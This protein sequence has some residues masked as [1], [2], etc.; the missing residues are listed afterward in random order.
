MAIVKLVNCPKCGTHLEVEITDVNVTLHEQQ[1]NDA[2]T[3]HQPAQEVKLA[4][5]NAADQKIEALRAAGINTSNL[6]SI[7]VAKGQYK[8]GCGEGNHLV[9]LEDDNPIF[10]AILKDGTIPDRRLFRRWVM[11]QVFHMLTETDHNGKVI[12]FSKLL[13]HKGYKYQWTMVIEELRVQAKLYEN[14]KENYLERNRWFNRSAVVEM[15]KDYIENIKE[16]VNQPKHPK[17]KGEPYV[18]FDKNDIFLK[19]IPEKVNEP[20]RKAL[21][22]IRNS[23]HPGSLHNAVE[24]FYKLIGEIWLPMDM[25]QSKAFVDAYKGAGAF[26]TL[27][28]LIL[29]HGCVFHASNSSEMSM[30]ESIDHLNQTVANTELEGY[31]LFGIMKEFIKA[32]N[33]DIAA[34]QAEWRK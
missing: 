9:I 29:F 23:K 6:F 4:K 15:A 30:K 19:D 22:S 13:S 7:C 26:F 5:K 8:V 18:R 25:K 32:N 27:K 14:D 28:N 21:T 12:G 16:L 2:A 17:C 31:K 1:P 20:L 11:A 34:K 24:N 10:N 33:I 3:A